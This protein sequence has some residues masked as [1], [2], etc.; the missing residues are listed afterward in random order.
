MSKTKRSKET[1]EVLHLSDISYTILYLIEYLFYIPDVSAYRC[2]RHTVWFY[3]H[4][5]RKETYTHILVDQFKST[6]Y[7]GIFLL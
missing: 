6:F 4:L 7:Q 2:K 5:E 3:I 1:D